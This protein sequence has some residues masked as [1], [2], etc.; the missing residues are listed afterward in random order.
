MLGNP[1]SLGNQTVSR[2]GHKEE[3]TEAS[4]CPGLTD[5]L[6]DVTLYEVHSYQAP[7]LYPEKD[8]PLSHGMSHMRPAP[9]FLLHNINPTLVCILKQDLPFLQTL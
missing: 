7:L 6:T 1:R 5:N 2:E 9:L 3:S 8:C 4:L